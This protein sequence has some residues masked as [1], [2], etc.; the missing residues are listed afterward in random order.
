MFGENMHHVVLMNKTSSPLT[1]KKGKNIAEL[2]PRSTD[3]MALRFNARLDDVE[4]VCK[5]QTESTTHQRPQSKSSNKRKDIEQHNS[6]TADRILTKLHKTKFLDTT[7][8][9]DRPIA[10]ALGPTAAAKS[11][12]RLTMPTTRL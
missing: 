11:L 9:S 5:Q 10:C 7:T 3:D 1:I 12:T 8:D 2:H 4:S 6:T